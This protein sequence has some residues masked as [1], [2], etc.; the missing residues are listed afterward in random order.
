M[1]YSI[2]NKDELK[3]LDELDDLQSKI[4]QV[5]LNEKLGKQSYHY[6][7]KELFQTFSDTLENT[8]QEIKKI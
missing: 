1:T 5:R 3:D 8:S 4:K 6:E 2:K 7:I